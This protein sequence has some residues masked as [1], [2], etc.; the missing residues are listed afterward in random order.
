MV[1]HLVE[2]EVFSPFEELYSYSNKK[3]TPSKGVPSTFRAIFY[4]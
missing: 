2:L 1:E 4:L 3:G